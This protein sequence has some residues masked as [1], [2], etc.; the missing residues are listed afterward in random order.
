LSATSPILLGGTPRNLQAIAFS[1]WIH[2]QSYLT[3]RGGG[4]PKPDKVNMYNLTEP[5]SCQ[6]QLDSYCLL[7]QLLNLQMK[8]R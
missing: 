7:E 6:M 8:T 5:L 4:F 2:I 1:G 3:Y